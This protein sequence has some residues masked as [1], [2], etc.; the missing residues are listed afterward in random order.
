MKITQQN[1]ALFLGDT[2]FGKQD[3]SIKERIAMKK[4]L[5]QKEALHIVGTVNKS[6][7]KMDANV[8]EIR[9]R[10][11]QLQE[12]SKSANESLLE[13]RQKITDKKEE[14]GVKD[15]S[16]E[17]AD[18]ELLMKEYDI[19][20]HG[21][22]AGTL[23]QEEQERLKNMGEM[24]DYQKEAMEAYVQTDYYKTEIE[25]N[26][27]EMMANA[28]SIRM[29]NMERLKT[30]GMVDAKKAEEKIMAAASDEAIAMMVDDVKETM[31]E[32]AEE[33]QEVA[34]AR[35][36]KKEEQEERIEAAKEDKKEAEAAA[37]EAKENASNLTEQVVDADNIM[38]DVEGE[39][40]KMLKEQELLEEEIKG[41]LVNTRM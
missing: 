27:R 10:I 40:K 20:K 26:N 32:K 6:E 17:Q 39:V 3:M 34:D 29:I 5:H 24:T 30:H 33:V 2:P 7:Q 13:Y 14:Y 12:E 36:E 19:K 9:G 35:A 28:F 1:K 31:D 18:L 21:S 41:I 22:A 25:R 16:K 4:Q 23:T 8:E 38:Q 15:D 11:R 37:E